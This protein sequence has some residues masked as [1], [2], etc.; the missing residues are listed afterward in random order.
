MTKLITTYTYLAQ[1]KKTSNFERLFICC[2]NLAGEM[3]HNPN[4]YEAEDKD[5]EEH[6]SEICSLLD[7]NDY[8]AFSV[9]GTLT[10]ATSA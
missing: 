2:L 9:I 7:L 3:V 8:A 10:R 6:I 5:I 4:F 1:N